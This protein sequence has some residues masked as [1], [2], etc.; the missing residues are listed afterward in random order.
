VTSASFSLQE[1]QHV[2]VFHTHSLPTTHSL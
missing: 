1:A 2:Y